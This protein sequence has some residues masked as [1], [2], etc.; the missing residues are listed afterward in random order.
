MPLATCT[1]SALEDFGKGQD[2]GKSTNSDNK[3]LVR[4]LIMVFYLHN[5]HIC[6][7]Q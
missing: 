6:A 2:F 1:R 5:N 4:A 3:I 7:I